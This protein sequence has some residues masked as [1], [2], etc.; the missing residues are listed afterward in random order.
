MQGLS[1]GTVLMHFRRKF[2][3]EFPRDM[4]GTVGLDVVLADKLR[5][6]EMKAKCKCRRAPVAAQRLQLV[7][8]HFRSP[9]VR[10]GGRISEFGSISATA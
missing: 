3:Q 9:G 10:Y 7:V 2:D 4:F 6:A 5:A 8:T 1:L